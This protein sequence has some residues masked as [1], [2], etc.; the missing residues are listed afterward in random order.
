MRACTTIWCVGV[1]ASLAL[2]GQAAPQSR[3]AATG[4]A[5][6]VNSLDNMAAPTTPPPLGGVQPGGP[7]PVPDPGVGGARIAPPGAREPRGNPLWAIPLKSMTYTRDRP[8]FTPSR[9]PPAPPVAYVEPARPA[10]VAKPA[11]P[12]RPR[13][14]LIG[15]VS[16]EKDKIAIFVDETTREVIRLRQDQGYSGWILR[17]VQGRETTLEKLPF[18]VIL[19]LPS[20]GDESRPAAPI[21]VPAGTIPIP[22][23]QL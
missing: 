11:E 7:T 1:A 10:P 17:S 12:E 14:V 3:L 21:G 13:L 9:R 23:D 20:P 2:C 22:G 15:L 4:P 19:A 18:T 8:L 16:G 6:S 5:G